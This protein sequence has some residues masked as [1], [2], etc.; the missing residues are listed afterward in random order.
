[1]RGLSYIAWFRSYHRARYAERL[2][3]AAGRFERAVTLQQYA[4]KLWQEM[5]A[6][7][8]EREQ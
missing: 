6:F 2:A 3:R 7:G 8:W 4:D 1:M 5:V